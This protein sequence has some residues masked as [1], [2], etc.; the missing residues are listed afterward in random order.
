MSI[1]KSIGI[2]LIVGGALGLLY[3][4]FTYTKETHSAQLGPIVLAV[5]ER[6]TIYVPVILSAAA[7]ALGVALLLT[8]RIK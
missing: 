8:L 1:G 5:Q 6:E 7:I 3:G 4:G 2:L